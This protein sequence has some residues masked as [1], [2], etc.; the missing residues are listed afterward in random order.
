[1]GLKNVMIDIETL[2]IAKPLQPNVRISQ[3][4]LAVFDDNFHI[5][6]TLSI[7]IDTSKQKDRIKD[8]ETINW[9]MKQ[10]KEVIKSVFSN[11]VDP[12]KASKTIISFLEN[13]GKHKFR[14]WSNHVLFDVVAFE[15]FLKDFS[16]KT[17]D[18]FYRYNQIVDYATMVDYMC[19]NLA[20]SKQT[21]FNMVNETFYDEYPDFKQ[22]NALD[23]CIYQIYVLKQID[24]MLFGDD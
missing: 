16:E 21:F 15:S 17:G 11:E 19:M 24:Q 20:I 2:A 4:G 12:Y 5:T 22:H 23:D 3:I 13:I 9:W 10:P 7:N 6:D 14:F 8:Q 18:D 1:M